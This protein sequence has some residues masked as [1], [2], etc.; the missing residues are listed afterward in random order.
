MPIPTSHMQKC[1]SG[2]KALPFLLVGDGEWW[3][4]SQV[5]MRGCSQCYGGRKL[6]PITSGYLMLVECLKRFIWKDLVGQ[7]MVSGTRNYFFSAVDFL[8][9]T[10]TTMPKPE[11]VSNGA[12]H[13]P[14]ETQRSL[15]SSGQRNVTRKGVFSGSESCWETPFPGI[16]S[17]DRRS[18]SE[19]WEYLEIGNRVSATGRYASGWGWRWD[20]KKDSM[21][22]GERVALQGEKVPG[23]SH[24]E[25]HPPL[26]LSG[27]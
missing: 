9:R 27:L 10:W 18:A 13:D 24:A 20:L 26:F 4:F 16:R 25:S 23:H 15:L 22:A 2:G 7:P 8:P 12:I 5:W 3:S 19:G 21:R 1:L 17:P 6:I 14:P 11:T